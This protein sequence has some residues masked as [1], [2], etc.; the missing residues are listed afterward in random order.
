MDENKKTLVYMGL[1]L[2]S[3]LVANLDDRM[4]QEE[5]FV[6][7]QNNMDNVDKIVVD[8]IKDEEI[9]K[10][11]IENIS[12]KLNELINTIP[13]VILGQD[14]IPTYFIY[15]LLELAGVNYTK[16][17]MQI[18]EQLYNIQGKERVD[19][20]LRNTL[21]NID[22]IKQYVSTGQILTKSEWENNETKIY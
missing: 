16:Q 15:G 5:V 17:K 12:M 18:L 7:L 22:T 4:R 13:E 11:N 19:E 10:K 14:S 9:H 20:A 3:A 1:M 2:G 6:E 8:Y 21:Y